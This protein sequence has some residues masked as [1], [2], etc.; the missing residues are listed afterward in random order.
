MA[1]SARAAGAAS[2]RG[3]ALSAGMLGLVLGAAAAGLGAGAPAVAARAAG[4]PEYAVKA[5][6]VFNFA[7]FVDW[8]AGAFPAER[9]FVIGVL[10]EDPFGAALD[11][12]VRGGAL[13]GR[14]VAVARYR[15]AEQAAACQVLFIARSE[16]ALQAAALKALAGKP[17]LTVGDAEDFLSA[18][19]MIRLHARAGRIRFD[20]NKAAA[21][22][23]GL[24]ISAQLLK[25]AGPAPGGPEP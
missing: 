2:R 18:G 20:V 12:I 19:G 8:P 21:D 23:A 15:S 4:L 5:A 17:V 14:P 7:K 25:L 9:P 16:R 13:Q 11:E 22:K 24:R 6:F 3:A 1:F 10:G